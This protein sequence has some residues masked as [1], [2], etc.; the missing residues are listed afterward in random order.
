MPWYET[1]SVAVQFR[2]YAVIADVLSGIR[3]RQVV[4][5]AAAGGQDTD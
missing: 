3:M 5:H 2:R 4:M 1:G